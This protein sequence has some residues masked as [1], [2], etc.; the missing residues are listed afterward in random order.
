MSLPS[1]LTPDQFEDLQ[2]TTSGEFGGLGI[3]VTM[4]DGF[5]KVVSPMDGTPAME[6]GIEA[7]DFITHVD[8]ESLLGLTLDEAVEMMR[9]PVGSE[10]IITVVREDQPE[11]FDV[12]IIRDTITLTAVRTRTEGETVVLRVTTFNDQTTP[13]LEEGLAEEI[14]AAEGAVYA[15]GIFNPQTQTQVTWPDALV[16]AAEDSRKGG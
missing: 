1:Y 6:E 8:G 13:N 16:A 15:D 14:A 3:E 10:I 5:V 4:E 2:S 7:G 12:S 11:P 9:G